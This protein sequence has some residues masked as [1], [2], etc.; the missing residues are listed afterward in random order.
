M[1]ADLVLTNGVVYTV[2][3]RRSRHEALAVKDGRIVALGRAAEAAEWSGPRTRTVDLGGRLVLPGFVDAHLHPSFAVHELFEVDL[4]DCRSVEECLD[5]VARFAAERPELA[6]IRG[7]G[8]FPTLVPMEDMTAE[9]LDRVVPDRP[10]CLNDDSVHAQWVNSDVLRRAGLGRDDPGWDGAV[11][12]RLADGSPRGLLHEAFPW[13]DRAMPDY[14]AADRA[15][16][17]RHLQREIAARYGLTLLHEAGVHPGESILDAYRLLEEGGELTARFCLS[18]ML[19]PD[20]PV[21]EQIEA[22]VEVRARFTG[23]LVRAA[24]VK[25]FVDGVIETHTGFLAEPYADRPGFRGRPIWPAEGL[26]AASAA[27]AKAGFQLHYHAIGDA[28]VSLA[29][30]AVAAARAS[31]PAPGRDLITHLQLMDP[32]DLARMAEL[33]IV[34]LTQPYWFSKDA[35]YDRDVYRPFLGDERAAHQYPM[36]SLL[37]AGVLVAGSSDYPV[38][39]PPDPLL[40]IQR[41]VLRRDPLAPD[42]SSE[43][44]PEEAVDVESMI[45]AFTIAGARANFLEAETGI[46]RGRQVGRPRRPAG[47]HPA[48]AGGADP[49]GRG[50]THRLPRPARPRDGSLRGPRRCV[51]GL[52]RPGFSGAYS[53]ERLPPRRGALDEREGEQL[54]RLGDSLAAHEADQHA[55]RLAAVGLGVVL[56]RRHRRGAGRGEAEVAGAG[57]QQFAGDV[58]AELRGAPQD[59]DRRQLVEPVDRVW[60]R[61]GLEQPRRRPGERLLAVLGHDLEPRSETT[62]RAPRAV[63]GDARLRPVVRGHPGH[64]RDVA[65]A[66]SFEVIEDEPCRRLRVVVDPIAVVGRVRPAPDGHEGQVVRLQRADVAVSGDRVRDDRA[67]EQQAVP[68]DTAFRV[69]DDDQRVLVLVGD[70]GHA[71]DE[72]EVVLEVGGGGRRAGGVHG[73]ERE[74]SGTARLEAA[75]SRVRPVPEALDR[76]LHA[77]PGDGGDRPLSSQGVR[78]RRRRDAGHARHV[79]DVHPLALVHR[80]HFPLA[81]G[82]EHSG[83]RPDDQNDLLPPLRDWSTLPKYRRLTGVLAACSLERRPTA[84]WSDQ[85]VRHEQQTGEDLRP[86]R[87]RGGAG[88]DRARRVVGAVGAAGRRIGLAGVRRRHPAHRV[89]RRPRQP[90]PVHRGRDGGLRSALPHLRPRLRLR[91]RR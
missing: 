62:L 38:S 76:V 60:S 26:L 85:G 20:L 24:A 8:W 70:R 71:P 21:D 69:R 57:D 29:V 34:A 25:L 91:P 51:A 35:V 68:V 10:V 43:L 16:G 53:A 31:A 73:A 88:A 30:D 55:R 74:D 9:A 41:G 37:D 86:R 66:V 11:I 45:A 84:V 75:G 2:D 63:R 61:P 89:D 19:D 50:G 15:A 1:Q 40:A 67:V 83:A 80:N 23:P 3:A 59:G 64:D 39:P 28:A 78:N 12:E 58:D 7:G 77:L 47:G 32:R 87:D 14:D 4:A 27:A 13:V 79:L 81:S 46:A 82:F 18:L 72:P 49:R 54:V 42:T 22:A 65:G 56:D 5:R 17:L 90:E 52:R 6:A 33:G 44:W 48:D 36:R